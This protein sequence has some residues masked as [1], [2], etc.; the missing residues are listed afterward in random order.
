[1]ASLESWHYRPD[2]SQ[3]SRL[4]SPL[5]VLLASSKG[6]RTV[7]TKPSAGSREFTI[8]FTPPITNEDVHDF[9]KELPIRLFGMIMMEGTKIVEELTEKGVLREHGPESNERS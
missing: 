7:T 1:M 3:P 9:L 2:T 6:E 8:S 5:T 4:L